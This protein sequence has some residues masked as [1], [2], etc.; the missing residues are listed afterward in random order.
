[1]PATGQEL[2]PQNVDCTMV[3]PTRSSVYPIA[4]ATP[5]QRP[6][7]DKQAFSQ[8]PVICRFMA[9]LVARQ[10]KA[11]KAVMIGQAIIEQEM[12]H[13]MAGKRLK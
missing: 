3:G 4:S 13:A 2:L 12:G 10:Q 9:R 11:M 8:P 1:M 5:P 6:I 7:P